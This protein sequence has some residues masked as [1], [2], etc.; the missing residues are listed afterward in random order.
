MNE[1]IQDEALRLER[2]CMGFY[3]EWNLLRK[4]LAGNINEEQADALRF[5]RDG[6]GQLLEEQ[7]VCKTG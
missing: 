4:D 2:L 7:D 3:C 6:I 1:P 5:V